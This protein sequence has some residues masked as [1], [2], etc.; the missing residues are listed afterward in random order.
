MK[1]KTIELIND[2]LTVIEGRANKVSYSVDELTENA[3]FIIQRVGEIKQKLKEEKQRK[4]NKNHTYVTWKYVTI[5]ENG[6]KEI[7]EEPYSITP[8]GKIIINNKEAFKQHLN[9]LN[10]AYENQCEKSD[11]MDKDLLNISEF[12]IKHENNIFSGNIEIKDGKIIQI[13]KR[14]FSI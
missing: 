5:N 13:N 9:K 6:I 14:N 4:E 2:A 8:S 11:P 3:A 12:I 1:T 10:K 7:F